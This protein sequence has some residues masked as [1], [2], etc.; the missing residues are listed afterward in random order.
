MKYKFKY[1]PFNKELPCS[2]PEKGTPF[3][4][5]YDLKYLGYPVV[6][7]PMQRFAFSTNLS[8]EIPDGY[9]GRIAPRSGLAF[10]QGIDVLA[11][12]IDSDYRGEIKVILINLSDKPSS[13]SSGDKIAQIIFEKHYDFTLELADELDDT[14]RGEKG[15]GSTGK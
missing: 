7:Q 15:F 13:F 2:V 1:K 5:G 8:L 4:A 3:A 12:I 11:G 10:K 14:S 6:L 9:F